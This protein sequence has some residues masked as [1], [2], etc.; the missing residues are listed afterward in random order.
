MSMKPL[1]LYIEDDADN[2]LLTE[3]ILGA[4]GWNVVTAST[5]KQGLLKAD[6]I[7]P[8]I[9]LL[10]I[11]LPDISGYDVAAAL[12]GNAETALAN[13]PIIAITA[14]ALQGDA[15]K[16]LSSGCDSYIAKPYDI[17]DLVTVCEKFIRLMR[18]TGALFL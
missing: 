8:D 17:Q 12:R 9:V 11:N 18:G 7:H 10:D 15:V 13:V 5:G 1:I 6:E 16:A 3:R 4:R 2:A 14:Y